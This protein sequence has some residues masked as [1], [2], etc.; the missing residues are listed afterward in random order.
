VGLIPSSIT[1]TIVDIGNNGGDTGKAGDININTQN[2]EL[3]RSGTINADNLAQ[4]NAGNININAEQINI[5]QVGNPSA[6][7]SSITATIGFQSD[8]DSNG[9]NITI[10]TR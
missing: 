5:G 4:G 7:T 10:D 8:S 2:L 1:S 6:P 9:G 3:S